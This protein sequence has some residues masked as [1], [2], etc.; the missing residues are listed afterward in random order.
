MKINATTIRVTLGAAMLLAC[1][2]AVWAAPFEDCPSEAFLVQD[3]V[4]RLYG[5]NL[6]TG[7]YEELTADMGTSGKIN[8]IGFNFHD[9][10]IYGF[11]YEAGTIAKIGSDYQAVP[12]SVSNLPGSNFYVGD[13]SLNQNAYYMYRRGSSY[14]LYRVSLDEGDSD[15]LNTVRITDGASLDLRIYDFAFHPDTN[16]LY[17]VDSSG[18]LLRINADT[19]TSESLGNVGQN[20]TFGA[21]Y[22]DVEGNFYI[23]RN[24][25]GHIFRIDVSSASPS[26]EFFAFGPSSSNNDGARCAMAPI[27][28][29][30][31]TVDFG[32]APESYGTSLDS[33]GARHEIVADFHLGSLNEIDDGVEF[34]TAFE[35]GLGTLVRVTAQDSGY[36]NAWFDWNQNG[37]FDEDEQGIVDRALNSGEQLVLVDVPDSVT[38]GDTWA[39]FRFTSGNGL[40]ATGGVSDGEVE[41]YPISLVASGNSK[42]FYPGASSYV[43]L[44][45]EDN[46]PL[47]GDYDMNDVVMAYRTTQ[48]VSAQNQVVR[49]DIEGELLAMGASYHNGFAVRLAGVPTSAVWQAGVVFQINGELVLANPVEASVV[50]QDSDAVLIVSEDLWQNI[51]L[52]SGCL[53]YRTQDGCTDKQDFRFKISVPLT[54]PVALAQAP[55]GK[56]D[57]FIFATNETYHG[58]SFGGQPGRGLEVH[59]KNHAPTGHVN[60]SYL[61]TQDDASNSDTGIYFSTSTGLPWALEI[62]VLWKHPK[63]Y[64][65]LLEAYADFEA[66]ATSSGEAGGV[67]YQNPTSA[68][69]IDN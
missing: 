16:E 62:P 65:D 42:V 44:A 12:L 67:W 46:W 55:T 37:S 26:A 59:L 39:R 14:G 43:T 52:A 68:R 69:V 18:T 21:V 24:S 45:Y 31:S 61:G 41:D 5:V 33:N 64:V 30:E 23:S 53:F 9:N 54:T 1:A 57:P 34:V 19:G 22:F 4:A 11:L 40:G 51:T 29:P 3:S 35:S 15:Y 2:A 17:S 6:A 10:Y 63:E 58:S 8:G 27:I 49:Y 13:V 20:G 47:A 28:S 25:D 60:S 66:F 32:D 50:G 48:Y 38:S 36:L 7:Y 56:L